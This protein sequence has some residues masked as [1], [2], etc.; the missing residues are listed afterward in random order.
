MNL[1]TVFGGSDGLVW[2]W[3]EEKTS[4]GDDKKDSDDSDDS[5]DSDDDDDS[6]ASEKSK[7]TTKS[8]LSTKSS[9]SLKSVKSSVNEP[10]MAAAVVE[11]DVKIEVE[12]HY[13]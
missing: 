11:P 3:W 1:I 9:K 2:S 4:Y 8:K 6:D 5:S 12:R 10:E 13:D 7:K